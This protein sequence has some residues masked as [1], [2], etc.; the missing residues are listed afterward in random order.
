MPDAEHRRIAAG[1]FERANQVIA[2]G[3][4]DYG[5]RLL[6]SCCKL[7]PANLIYRQ[8]LRRTEK[9]KYKNNLRGS[10]LAWLTTSATRAKLKT[11]RQRRDHVKVLELAESVLARNPW[12]TGVQMDQ[13]E[14]A[15]TLGLRDLAIWT[16]EQARQKNPRDLK[17]NR[18]LAR[19]YERRGNYTQA[20][21][22]WEMIRRAAPT[23]TEATNKAKDLAAH[24]TIARGQYQQAVTNQP[25]KPGTPVAPRVA[26]AP[27]PGTA[28]SGPHAPGAGG[29]SPAPAAPPRPA[30]KEPTPAP[31]DRESP[32][33]G[34]EALVLPGDRSANEVARLR[35]RIEA[36]PTNAIGYLQLAALYR[37]GGQLD[38]AR[39]LLHDA[40][41][42]TGNDFDI[43][44]EL[45]DLD[46]E[47]F[48][49]NL[50]HAEERLR[51][52]QSDEEARK[53]RVRLLKEI[54]SRELDLFRRKADRFPTEMAH[55]FELGVRLLRGGQVDEAIRELQ[56][57][58][59][60]PRHHWRSLLY[61]GY[62]FKTRQN[63]RLAKRNFEEALQ[64]LP[65]GE[66]ATRKEILFQLAQ[67]AAEAGDLATAVELANDLANLDFA[68][69][70]IGQ[71][72]DEWETK[73]RQAKVA[74][75][76]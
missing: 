31:A 49:R 54:N 26:P 17:L 8:A 72:L 42:P 13:A 70:D 18:V 32:L 55:R 58:R 34:R 75:D 56:A 36:D 4:Y 48:R 40:L 50:A 43:S 66:D 38:A 28:G 53:A 16:L 68:Y 59:A 9:T 14:A 76:K 64:N 35:A 24:E 21:A 57:A 67:G 61:L 5:I 3:N 10:W 60:D 7:D 62:C 39:E 27:E 69:R 44:L 45:A 37:R 1:Q 11:A 15:E 23:D 63:W 12:D 51:V 46:I 41:G 29:S 22:L 65:P 33:I 20:I 73:L 52:R 74:T 19:L 71:L 30:A 6:L 25:A 47:P 2:T